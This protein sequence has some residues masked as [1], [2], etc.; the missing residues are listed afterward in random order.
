MLRWIYLILALPMAAGEVDDASQNWRKPTVSEV[1][2][3]F[4]IAT[5]GIPEKMFFEA[6]VHQLN[7]TAGH[8]KG[9]LFEA[10]VDR[11]LEHGTEL[12]EALNETP[13]TREEMAQRLRD[14]DA[15]YKGW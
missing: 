12:S 3:L 8:Q 14:F 15:N 11:S 1:T 13:P 6:E 10:A 4:Q 2:R 9:E 5:R 7:P